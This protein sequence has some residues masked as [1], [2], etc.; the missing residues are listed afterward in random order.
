MS[1]RQTVCCDN[2]LLWHLSTYTIHPRIF[3]PP[4]F[5]GGWF[6]TCDITSTLPKMLCEIMSTL[7]WS[8]IWI[9]C[10]KI[11]DP[12]VT[13]WRPASYLVAS[14]RFVTGFCLTS[15]QCP[16]GFTAKCGRF[17]ACF[18][19]FVM[20]YHLLSKQWMFCHRIFL[21]CLPCPA[22]F[23]AKCGHF[24]TTISGHLWCPV[25]C[26]A[27][28]GPFVTGFFRLVCHV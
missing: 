18:W 23:S 21:T 27:N 8:E 11:L 1:T 3:H 2:L 9:V 15:L 16:G 20:S 26:S 4:L 13:S 14:G 28:S 10:H 22:S 25:A 17:V 12:F 5:Q 19:T 7:S 24:V 6:V